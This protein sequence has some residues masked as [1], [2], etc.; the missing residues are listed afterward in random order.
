MLEFIDTEQ[1]QVRFGGTLPNI[2]DN[3]YYPFRNT[4]S[5]L[6][7][8][9][10]SPENIVTEEPNKQLIMKNEEM[11]VSQKS[12]SQLSEQQKSEQISVSLKSVQQKSE[13]IRSPHDNHQFSQTEVQSTNDIGEM[14]KNTINRQYPYKFI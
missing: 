13:Q 5:H 11:S 14:A 8:L 12:V 9:Q 3:Q 7:P 6:Q 1:L 10:E 2:P 4:I